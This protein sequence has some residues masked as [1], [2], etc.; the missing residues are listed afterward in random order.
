MP[1]RTAAETQGD[2]E[3]HKNTIAVFPHQLQPPKR[4]FPIYFLR[5]LHI[6]VVGL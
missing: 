2:Q 3:L 4:H 5:L 6:H 1:Q